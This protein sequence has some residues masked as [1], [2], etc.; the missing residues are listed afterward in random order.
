MF[1]ISI[2]LIGFGL[3]IIGFIYIIAYLNYLVI[4]YTFSEY[5][6]FIIT[7]MESLL[8][9]WGI[10]LISIAIFMKGK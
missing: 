9:F 5:L 7:H 6:I 3:A 2:F 4:G 10:L 8:A 1:R